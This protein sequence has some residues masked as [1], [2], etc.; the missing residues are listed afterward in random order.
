MKERNLTV[1][2]KFLC[3]A[4]QAIRTLVG[5]APPP[6]RPDPAAAIPNPELSETE[7]RHAAGLMRVNH[8]GEVC[9][10]ALYQGQALTARLPEVRQEMEQAASEETDHLSWCEN[11]L[12]ALGST[13]SLLNPLW[14]GASFSLG[15]VAGLV[16][17]RLSLGFVA[18]TEQQVCEH[19]RTHLAA[20]PKPDSA[21]RAVVGQMLEDEGR[22]AQKALAAGGIAFPASVKGL[23]SL[24]ARVM[25]RA[26]YRI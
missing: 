13:T 3:G 11:R 16:S 10:Q 7:R 20:L 22:H 23:M 21:S 18:A 25:T 12:N 4:D 8:S 5:G 17:D 14:Y 15:A 19:L 1:F 24:V 9:A 26:S 2:D 6:A